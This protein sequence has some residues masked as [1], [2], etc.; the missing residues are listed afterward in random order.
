MFY[1]NF[2]VI[3]KGVHELERNGFRNSVISAIEAA[4]NK[5]KQF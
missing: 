5:A 4:T 3:F 2:Y 1:L